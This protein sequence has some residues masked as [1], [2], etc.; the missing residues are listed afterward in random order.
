V[1]IQRHKRLRKII[2]AG[3]GGTFRGVTGVPAWNEETE[4]HVFNAHPAYYLVYFDSPQT[5]STMTMYVRGLTPEKVRQHL[6]ESNA[7]FL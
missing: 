6:V 4:S 7:K 5:G 1:R 2:K 3:G